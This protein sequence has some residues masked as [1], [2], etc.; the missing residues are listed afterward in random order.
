MQP[1]KIAIYGA[2]SIGCFIGGLLLHAG[3]RVTF[4]AGPWIAAELAAYGLSLTDYAGL[5]AHLPP[6]RLD[7]QTAP[8]FL[9][10]AGLVLLT[11]KSGDTEAAAREIAA[12]TAPDVPV[13]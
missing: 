7:V 2:G 9:R 3:R 6:D 8:E 4:L 11:V 1:P 12:L 5:S 10:D 13:V